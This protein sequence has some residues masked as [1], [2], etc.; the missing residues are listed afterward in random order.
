MNIKVG[1]REQST[2]KNKESELGHLYQ[3]QTEF[4]IFKNYKLLKVDKYFKIKL[5]ANIC[6]IPEAPP[7]SWNSENQHLKTLYV[8]TSTVR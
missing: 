2:R 4:W 3:D 5:E 6:R 7:E 1:K 8:R